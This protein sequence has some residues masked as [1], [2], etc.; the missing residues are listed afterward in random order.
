MTA[1]ALH[2]RRLNLRAHVLVLV[3]MLLLPCRAYHEQ[4]VDPP[5]VLADIPEDEGWLCPACDA[6]VGSVFCN[7]VAISASLV[8]VVAGSL[9]P[10]C[11]QHRPGVY[12]HRICVGATVH[13]HGGVES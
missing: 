6:K 2:A 8:I 10:A 7:D 11:E 1:V 9:A 3:P 12:R 13:S 4:C 5:V